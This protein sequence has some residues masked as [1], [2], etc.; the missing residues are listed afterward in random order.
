MKILVCDWCHAKVNEYSHWYDGAQARNM[1][2]LKCVHEANGNSSSVYERV[3][4][5]KCLNKLVPKTEEKKETETQNDINTL[6]AVKEY[7]YYQCGCASC[8]YAIDNSTYVGC[9]I[10]GVPFKW[11]IDTIAEEDK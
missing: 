7:C 2:E 9:A 4:C 11:K 5:S 8:K 1:Y 3:I 10:S 6:K